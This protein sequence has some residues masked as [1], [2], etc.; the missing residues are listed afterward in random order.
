MVQSF[1]VDLLWELLTFYVIGNLRFSLWYHGFMVVF[2]CP[3]RQSALVIGFLLPFVLSLLKQV[4]TE[5]LLRFNHKDQNRSL[6][7]ISPCLL[8]LIPQRRYIIDM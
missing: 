6:V 7:P 2:L 3:S 8:G 4:D 5:G 1:V